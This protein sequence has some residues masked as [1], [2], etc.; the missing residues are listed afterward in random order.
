[1]LDKLQLENLM[2]SHERKEIA[3]LCQVSIEKV[4]YWIK[5]YSL[6]YERIRL[7]KYPENL[8]DIQNDILTA[9]ML[10][11]G[12]V[13]SEGRF[14]LKMKL[15]SLEYVNYI[16]NILK[17]FSK[18]ISFVNSK[19]P[20]REGNIVTSSD[21]I[22]EQC[23]F[24]TITH[25]LFLRT[26]NQWYVN[27]KKFV[28]KDIKINDRVIAHWFCQDGSN[29]QRSRIATLY[30]LSFSLDDVNFLINALNQLKIK[31]VIAFCRG[32]PYIRTS[33][34]KAYF[35]L[36]ERVSSH[37]TWNCMNYKKDISTANL[38]DKKRRKR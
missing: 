4:I 29:C 14:R 36:I 37:I 1:M 9:S 15:G 38:P 20:K 19:K 16:A 33:G 21:Q 22:S 26:R 34:H 30:T 28:C 2:K 5:K 35:S 3:E 17:P 8:S 11:D 7:N 27:S 23:C 12:M 32:K 25:P 6:S 10:G 24:Y 13:K 31:C 18:E